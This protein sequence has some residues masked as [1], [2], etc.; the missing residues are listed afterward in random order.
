M[1]ESAV[2]ISQSVLESG[3]I[4][5]SGLVHILTGLIY[6]KGKI[7]SCKSKVL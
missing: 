2:Y 7:R 5:I 1:E 3:E 6:S 4:G